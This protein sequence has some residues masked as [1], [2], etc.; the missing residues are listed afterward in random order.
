[1]DLRWARAATKHRISRERSRYVIEH[2]GLRFEQDP[3]AGAPENASPR[4]VFLGD[5]EDGA[6]LEVMAVELDDG[7]LLVIHAMPLR[8]RYRKQYEEAKKWRR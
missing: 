2:C 7:S 3:P 5:G 1:M 4:L 8:N 6:A